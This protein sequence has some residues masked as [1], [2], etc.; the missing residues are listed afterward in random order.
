MEHPNISIFVT[1]FKK[2]KTL[3]LRNTGKIERD[4]K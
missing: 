3:L 2:F 1:E 4:V